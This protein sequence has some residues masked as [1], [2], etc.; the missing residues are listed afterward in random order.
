MVSPSILNKLHKDYINVQFNYVLNFNLSLGWKIFYFIPTFCILFW[1]FFWLKRRGWCIHGEIFL[2][3]DNQQCH[4]L[5]STRIVKWQPCYFSENLGLGREKQSH[6]LGFI[7]K[8]RFLGRFL[9]CIIPLSS[10][11][12]HIWFIIIQCSR[13]QPPE[14]ELVKIAIHSAEQL[15]SYTASLRAKSSH[16]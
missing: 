1:S 15:N 7:G 6:G 13:A 11:Y 16:G 9:F 10:L 8:Y 12:S 5:S 4:L 3:F 14:G 2:S